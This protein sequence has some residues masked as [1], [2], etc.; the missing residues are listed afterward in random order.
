MPVAP[1][2]SWKS[3][4]SSDLIVSSSIRLGAIAING[5]NVYWNEGRP[6]EGGRNV[7]M[8]YSDDGNYREMT[9]ASLNV[10]SQVHEYGGGEYMVQDGRI[11]FSNFSDRCIY[12]KVGGG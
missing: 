4:I 10:R 5:G 9:P 1:Y 11:Y 7:I 6:T 2:G 12:R 8:R 3:P